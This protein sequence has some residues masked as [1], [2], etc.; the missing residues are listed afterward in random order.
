MPAQVAGDTHH[1]A[2]K[3]QVGRIAGLCFLTTPAREAQDGITGRL[4]FIGVFCACLVMKF[5]QAWPE[6]IEIVVCSL[7]EQ[8]PDSIY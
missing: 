2:N 3:E 7:G 6:D 1:L 8:S 4:R 5:L